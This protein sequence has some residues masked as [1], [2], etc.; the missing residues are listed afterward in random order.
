MIW[1]EKFETMPREEMRKWQG[2]KLRE[3]VERVYYNVPFY[4]RIMQEM[5]VFPEDLNSVD[6]LSRLP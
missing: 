2:Q 6:D 3:M 4:R 5:N 1:N